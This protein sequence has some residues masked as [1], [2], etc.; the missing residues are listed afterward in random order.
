MGTFFILVGYSFPC[1]QQI[2]IRVIILVCST[3]CILFKFMHVLYLIGLNMIDDLAFELDK[4][5]DI[6]VFYYLVEKR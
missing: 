2:K 5:S 6:H 4:F 3:F 1:P